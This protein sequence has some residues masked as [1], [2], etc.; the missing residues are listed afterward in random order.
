M[1]RTITFADLREEVRL[2]YDLPSFTATTFV[3]TT[4]VN[5]F[6]NK[7]LQA[8]YALLMECYGEDYFATSSTI[9]TLANTSL[10][11]LPTRFSKLI[12]LHWVRDS[13]DIVPIRRATVDD[14]VL[15]SY[16]PKSWTEYGPRYR[17]SG[18]SSV[19]W[20]PIPNAAYSVL[21]SYVA[22]PAD[23]SADADTFEAGQGWEDWVILDVCR[24]L[25]AREEKDPSVWLAERADAE[26]RIRSQAPER[27]ETEP[28]TLRD[29]YAIGESDYQ[30]RNRLTRMY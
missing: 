11:T 18:I 7:S 25:A 1:P 20:L 10:S 19:Q 4:A 13:D 3:S 16:D 8:Y 15:A 27:S 9:T 30:R 26:Q 28:L 6:I 22:L 24:K 5:S 21:C 17:L 14:M 2:R 29:A 12:A 23:L